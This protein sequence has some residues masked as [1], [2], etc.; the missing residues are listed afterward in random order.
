MFLD[1]LLKTRKMVT[2]RIRT[3]HAQY[4]NHWATLANRTYL[5]ERKFVKNFAPPVH[6]YIY[7]DPRIGYFF[8]LFSQ[9]STSISIK[10]TS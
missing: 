4:S 9:F 6:F 7:E 1:F 8:F 2:A 5:H 10:Y 3:L